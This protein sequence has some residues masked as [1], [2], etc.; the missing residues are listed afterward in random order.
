MYIA[1]CLF[2]L[3]WVLMFSV[4]CIN[5]SIQIG[6]PTALADRTVHQ[7]LFE[8]ANKFHGLYVPVGAL[9]G[10][11]DIKKM[12]DRGTLKVQQRLYDVSNWRDPI[13]CLFIGSK[14]YDEETSVCF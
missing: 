10:A 4:F 12:A 6:S 9:W 5:V 2:I 8:A 14:G 7:A 3:D 13:V 1:L 11:E